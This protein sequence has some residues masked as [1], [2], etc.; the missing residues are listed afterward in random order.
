MVP[1]VGV[2][3]GV[4]ALAVLCEGYRPGG[5]HGGVGCI[6]KKNSIGAVSDGYHISDR[7][8]GSDDEHGKTRSYPSRTAWGAAYSL[9]EKFPFLLERKFGIAAYDYWYG[10]SSC[11]IDLML[12]DQPVID[13][14]STEKKNERSMFGTRE[15]YDEMEALTAAW[16]AQNKESMVGKKVN[17]SEFMTKKV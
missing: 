9:G 13:Y 5:G 7:H 4:L 16:E 3:L 2:V 15:E 10:Y 12:A 8:D 11:Q 17:L 14:G 1:A 6:Q